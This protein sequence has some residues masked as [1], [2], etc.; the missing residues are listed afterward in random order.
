VNIIEM[1]DTVIYNNTNTAPKFYDGD[2]HEG[3]VQDSVNCSLACVLVKFG[4]TIYVCY[5]SDLTI[6]RKARPM[7][8]KSNLKAGMVVRQRGGQFKIVLADSISGKTS[9]AS[10]FS[11]T[12]DLKHQM[13]EYDIV[14][15]YE[16]NGQGTLHGYLSGDH[17]SILWEEEKTAEQ[18]ELEL[19][20]TELLEL[21]SK[22]KRAGALGHLISIVNLVE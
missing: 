20:E 6:V 10:M 16:T 13:K 9:R 19:M 15:V 18:I 14:A 17:L 3:V 21:I 12:N 22:Y 4:K 5:E 11:F 7:Y 8:S 1:G 2:D